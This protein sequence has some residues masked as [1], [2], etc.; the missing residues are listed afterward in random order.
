M[1]STL[2]RE[3][4]ATPMGGH[5]GIAKTIVRISENF[6]W[7]GL[8]SDVTQ[9]IAMCLDCQCTK[10]ETKKLVGLLCP[11]SVPHRPWEDLSLDFIIGLPPYHD[12][13][14]ILIVVDRLLKGMHLGMLPTVHTAHTVASLFL[15]LVVKIHGVPRSL[16]S[17]R[18]LLF[19]SKFWQEL[20]RLSRT[21]LRMSSAYHPQ[22]DSQIKVLNHVIEQY[23]RSFVHHRPSNWGKFLARA[24]YS[25]NTSWN[26]ATGTTPYEVTFG[27]KPFNFP[28]YIVGTSN[29]DVV[30]TMMTNRDEVFQLI[31]KK[32]LKAQAS[33]K[34]QA[35]TRRRDVN[36]HPGE[37]VLL[38]LRPHQQ[39]TAKGS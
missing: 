30:D 7:P 37:W 29:H 19:I 26:S 33:M 13:T 24:E 36:Y 10:Y 21:Q 31:R 6:Y 23:L 22:S 27:R 35:D 25:H 2:L 14:V 4:H 38:K 11:L 32:L 12:N 18:D 20:F 8:R 34:N 1:I 15:E 39:S 16:V 5:A 9:F 3:Y 28:A 17:D